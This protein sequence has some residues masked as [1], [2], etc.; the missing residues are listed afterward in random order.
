MLESMN[1]IKTLLQIFLLAAFMEVKEEN[2]IF[3]SN[4]RPVLPYTCSKF[5]IR[6][7]KYLTLDNFYVDMLHRF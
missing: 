6:K 4:S 5:C 3:N 2:A 7:E 1:V